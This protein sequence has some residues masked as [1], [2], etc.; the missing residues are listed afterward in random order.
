[1]SEDKQN[2]PENQPATLDQPQHAPIDRSRRRLSGLGVSAILTLASRPVLATNCVSPSAAASGNLSHHGT[3]PLCNGRTAAMWAS[4]GVPGLDTIFKSV[5]PNGTQSSRDDTTTFGAVLT[6]TDNGNAYPNPQPI[7][8]EFA[9]ALL[10]IRG[11]F[12]PASVLTDVQL[13]EM[14]NDW[15]VDGIFNPQAGANWDASHIVTYLQ[16]LQA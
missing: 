9:A 15:V 10:N 12:I 6:E 13:I 5:F 2:S 8:K 16:G 1:M 11:G 7:S 14:W 4:P 3:S